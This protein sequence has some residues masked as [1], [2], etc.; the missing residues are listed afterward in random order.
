MLSYV[1][2]GHPD[3]NKGK[4]LRTLTTHRSLP[5]YIVD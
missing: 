1:S 3:H 4:D 5:H 2:I